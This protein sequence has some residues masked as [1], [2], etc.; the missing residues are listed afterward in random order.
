MENKNKV[1]KAVIP[2]AGLGTRFL[3][4][5]KAQPKEMLPILNKPTLQYI[6][7]EAYDSGIT[8]I[9]VIIGRGKDSIVNHFDHSIELEHQLKKAGKDK[10]FL[11][12]RSISDK[13]NIYYIRQKEAKGLGHAI[14]CA[15]AFVAGEPFAVL[16]GDDIIVSEDPI[17]KQMINK[18]YEYENSVVAL[19]DVEDEDVDKYGII[20]GDKLTEDIYKIYDMIEKPKLEDAPSRLAIIGRYILSPEIFEIIKKTEP[21]INN[22]IQLTDALLGLTEIEDVYGYKFKGNRYDIGNKLGFV[23]ANLEFGLR[24]EM[25]G[26]QLKEYLNKLK[27][28]D[29]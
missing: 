10:E 21:G 26:E 16:L 29:F 15:E 9:L 2:A 14:S 6:V 22:E 23:K 1:R 12:L 20:R 24:D 19:I 25:I 7:E 4:A 13:V 5:T 27:L 8:D 3:P 28:S 11:E 18:Y 17:T